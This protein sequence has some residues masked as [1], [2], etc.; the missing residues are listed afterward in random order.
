M[1]NCSDKMTVEKIART[2]CHWLY[3]RDEYNP[4]RVTLTVWAEVNNESLPRYSNEILDSVWDTY[5]NYL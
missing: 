3:L 5:L 1:L 4:R 2:W